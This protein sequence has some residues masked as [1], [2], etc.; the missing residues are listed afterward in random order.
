MVN[1]LYIFYQYKKNFSE[2]T[3]PSMLSVLSLSLC[4]LDYF[5]LGEPATMS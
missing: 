1:L 2:K 4:I 5:T 3:A